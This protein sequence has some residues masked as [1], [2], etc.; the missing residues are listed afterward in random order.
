[1]TAAG[2]SF[3]QHH[4][5]QSL[6]AMIVAAGHHYARGLATALNAMAQAEASEFAVVALLPV[7]S[8][9]ALAF[10][11]ASAPHSS[12]EAQNRNHITHPTGQPS[13]LLVEDQ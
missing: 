4:Q 13:N 7:S 2:Q 8:K 3:L 11:P 12:S 6:A 5:L 1:M 10:A 9:Q